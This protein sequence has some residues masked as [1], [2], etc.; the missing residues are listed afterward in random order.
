M[1]TK[2]VEKNHTNTTFRA[3]SLHG[4]VFFWCVVVMILISKNGAGNNLPI[5]LVGRETWMTVLQFSPSPTLPHG[6]S[7]YPL[8][9]LSLAHG[10]KIET[11]PI[12]HHHM[13]GQ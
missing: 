9:Q 7:A 8:L 1:R 13:F 2:E 3:L 11:L 5:T 6:I 4:N 12:S 10:V